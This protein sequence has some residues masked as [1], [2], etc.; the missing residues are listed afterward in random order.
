MTLL[1]DNAVSTAPIKGVGTFIT[2][3]G[4][5]LFFAVFA[6][7]C[8]T[9]GRFNFVIFPDWILKVAGALGVPFPKRLNI[10]PEIRDWWTSGLAAPST[11]LIALAS[12]MAVCKFGTL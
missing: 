11:I 1:K 6:A 12:L 5:G 4:L 10:R 2:V 3:F 9:M 8:W 7:A